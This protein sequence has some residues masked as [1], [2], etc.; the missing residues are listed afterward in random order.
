MS[1][2]DLQAAFKLIAHNRDLADFEDPRPEKLVEKAERVLSLRFPPSYR[3][4]LKEYGCGDI[5]G[6]EFYGVVNE[7]FDNSTAP[8]AIWVTLDERKTSGLPNSLI[9]IYSP[10]D[11]LYYALDS[12]ECNSE[13]EWPVV[14]WD[15]G[16]SR[17]K[18][19]L[20]VVAKDFGEFLYS[21]IK[22]ALSRHT[23]SHPY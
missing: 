10:G 14:V 20:E 23:K 9:I 5:G 12:R 4:F 3:T 13:G 18:D 21:R 11:G 7:N 8:D 1:I 15:P 17:P 2:R 22:E 6:E 19:K 16:T